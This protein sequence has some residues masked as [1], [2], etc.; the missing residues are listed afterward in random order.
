MNAG[1]WRPDLLMTQHSALF[2]LR[3]AARLRDNGRSNHRPSVGLLEG[4]VDRTQGKGVGDE[5][6]KRIMLAVTPHEIQGLRDDPRLISGQRH[7]GDAP[8][9]DAAGL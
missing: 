2:S 8:E 5:L 1:H 7:Q 9:D 4:F 6:L 3:L